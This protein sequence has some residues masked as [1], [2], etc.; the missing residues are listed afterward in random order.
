MAEFVRWQYRIV[1]IGSVYAARNLGITLSYVGQRGW[2]L[3]TVFDKASH[4]VEGIEKGFILFKRGEEPVEE[5]DGP[6][7]EVWTAEQVAQ[8]YQA[9]MAE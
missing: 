1:S 9:T 5:R 3:Q 7:A 2:E 4:W 8:R 6:W